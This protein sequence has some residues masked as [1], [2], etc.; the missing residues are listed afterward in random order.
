MVK[1]KES[2]SVGEQMLSLVAVAKPEDLAVMALSITAKERE[3]TGLKAVRKVLAL[4]LGVEPEGKKPGPRRK[5]DPAPATPAS[6]SET[7]DQR[8]AKCVRYIAKNGPTPGAE[9]CR[10]FNIPPGSQTAVLSHEWFE[11]HPKGFTLTS[12]GNDAA[13]TLAGVG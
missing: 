7:S 2:A 5:A 13:R 11:R 10:L 1:E 3:L 8:R 6:N 9:L 4:T 12:L